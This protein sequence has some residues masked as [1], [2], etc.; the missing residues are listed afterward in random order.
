MSAI[1][2][3]LSLL[4]TV[5]ITAHDNFTKCPDINSLVLLGSNLV[6]IVF[7]FS[8]IMEKKVTLSLETPD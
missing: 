6:R 5:C 7:V 3:E 8:G 1:Q 2:A 4:E